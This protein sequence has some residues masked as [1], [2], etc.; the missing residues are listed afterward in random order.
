[1]TYN[2]E[3]AFDSST[4]DATSPPVAQI[5]VKTHTRDSDGTIY[6]TPQCVTFAEFDYQ[7]TRLSKEV[8]EAREKGR[9]HFDADP[10]SF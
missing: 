10:R 8:E 2:L 3:L 1:M 7:M 9:K 4:K 6:I 5:Y